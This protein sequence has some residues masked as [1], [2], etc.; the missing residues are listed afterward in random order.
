MKQVIGSVMTDN[1]LLR[2]V[3]VDETA[4]LTIIRNVYNAL[5]DVAARRLGIV[6][7]L[8]ANECGIK[9]MRNTCAL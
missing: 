1:E 4:R 6:E 3:L 2:S 7:V 8:K 5:D 9:T